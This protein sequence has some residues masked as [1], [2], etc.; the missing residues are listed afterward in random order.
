MSEPPARPARARDSCARGAA[1]RPDQDQL[2][3]RERL[4]AQAPPLRARG[5]DH[6][7]EPAVAQGLEEVVGQSGRDL[8]LHA[9]ADQG[10]ERRGG[11]LGEEL[12]RTAQ[13]QQRVR[14]AAEHRA[15]GVDQRRADGG[16][17]SGQAAGELIGVC[18]GDHPAGVPLEERLTESGFQ[19]ADLGTGGGLGETQGPGGPGDGA[20]LVDGKEGTPARQVVQ[21]IGSP[22]A[23]IDKVS[24]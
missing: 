10:S 5:G 3:V 1:R 24:E 14:G 12:G 15:E 4:R 11:D 2:L 18:R 22:I 20:Q 9:V 19:G 13:A 8:Q 7:V 16:E 21:P 6:Q 17:G 23:H